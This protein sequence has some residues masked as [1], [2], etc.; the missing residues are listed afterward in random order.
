MARTLPRRAGSFCCSIEAKA[1]LRSTTIVVGSARF[2]PSSVACADGVMP[3]YRC[4]HRPGARARRLD[5]PLQ[6]LRCLGLPRE[7]QR[8]L[9]AHAGPGLHGD[10]PAMAPRD[11]LAQVKAETRAR[12]AQVL[13]GRQPPEPR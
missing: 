9:A 2:S 12:D 7:G 1:Q 3:T 5:R 10:V 11:L 6:S 13:L 8:E 4:S